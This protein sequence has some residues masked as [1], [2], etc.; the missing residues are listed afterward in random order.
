VD[1]VYK[2]QT[3]NF[4]VDTNEE[5]KQTFDLS[6][7]DKNEEP[8]PYPNASLFESLQCELANAYRQIATLTEELEEMQ[9]ADQLTQ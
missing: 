9:I 5:S 1:T 3:L 7:D 4:V 2:T 6:L 8:N